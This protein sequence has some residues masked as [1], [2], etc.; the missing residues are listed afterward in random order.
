MTELEEV[1]LPD[2]Q[3]SAASVIAST[4]MAPN[5]KFACWLVAEGSSY[6]SAAEALNLDPRH[7]HTTA[8]RHGLD[9]LHNLRQCERGRILAGIK[10]AR[11]SAGLADL[12]P[13]ELAKL[14]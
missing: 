5:M 13:T 3:V 7:L 1:G 9:L 14:I 11:K 8:R 4:R 6:E 2:G 12:T 10:L